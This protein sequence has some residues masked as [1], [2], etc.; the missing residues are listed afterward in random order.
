M[1]LLTKLS[2]SQTAT[3]H[4]YFRIHHK[5]KSLLK[6]SEW[7]VRLLLKSRKSRSTWHAAR[8]RLLGAVQKGLFLTS[9]VQFSTATPKP[10]WLVCW[11]PLWRP[12]GSSAV[13]VARAMKSSI[14]V[15][16]P[17]GS[18]RSCRVAPIHF[19]LPIGCPVLSLHVCAPLPV[20][21]RPPAK[22][23]ACLPWIV[24]LSR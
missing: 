14:P 11:Q 19:W 18:A 24:L 9:C 7:H 10:V 22:G 6:L 13:E 23:P 12:R 16:C 20:P 2:A 4:T 15:N 21:R 3:W 17:W 5:Y 8:F 1:Y